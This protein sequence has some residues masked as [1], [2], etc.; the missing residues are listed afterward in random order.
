MCLRRNCSTA[1]VGGSPICCIVARKVGGT[2]DAGRASRPRRKGEPGGRRRGRHRVFDRKRVP[3][4]LVGGLLE[5]LVV[6]AA[7]VEPVEL[8]LVDGDLGV[9]DGHGARVAEHPDVDAQVGRRRDRG[10][11]Q[12][13]AGLVGRQLEDDGADG[14]RV[15]ADAQPER[16]ERELPGDVFV[17]DLRRPPATRSSRWSSAR[18][19]A[20]PRPPIG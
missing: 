10:E 11:L 1:P 13:Q 14:R 18:C 7:G 4:R 20:W 2:T 5:H 17:D 15:L 19:A 3:L 12:R 16:D 6:V 9:V 8:R